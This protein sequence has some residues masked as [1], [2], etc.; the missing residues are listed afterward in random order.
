MKRPFLGTIRRKLLSV[1]LLT[2]LVAVIVALGAMIGYDLRNHYDDL[3]SDMTTQSE[4]LGHMTAPA[5]TF[6]DHQLADQ[7]LGMLVARPQVRAAAIYTPRNEIFSTYAAKGHKQPIPPYPEP[8]SVRIEGRDLILFKRITSNGE[9]IGTV[10]LSVD[11]GFFERVLAYL[12]IAALV[13]LLAMSIAFL[14]SLRLQ[15]VV[16]H[17]IMAISRVAREVVEQRDY[18]RRADNTSDD[19]VGVLVDSFND[20]LN[21]IERRTRDLESSN[22]AIARE[23]DERSRAQQEIMR[24]NAELE[25]RVSVRTAQLQLSNE[26]LVAAKAGADKASQAKSEFLSSMSHEIRTPMN[27]VI[28]MVDVLHQTSL[29]DYQVEM[30]DLIRE[31]ALS[32]MTIIDDILDFSKIEAGK[33]ELDVGPLAV[34]DIVEKV[35]NMLDRLAE[36]KS[37]E[38]TMFI[39]P[40]IPAEVLGDA[41]RVRQVLTNLIN[42]AIKFSS[43]QDRPGIVSVRTVL[44]GEQPDQLFVEFQVSDNGIG[45]DEEIQA[46][47]F[48][49]FTQADSTTTRRFGGTGL[50]LSISRHLVALMNGHI[51]VQSMLGKGSVFTVRLPFTRLPGR[52]DGANAAAPLAGLQ[53]LA[54]GDLQGLADGI[55]TYLESAGARVHCVPS[56]TA[57]RMKAASAPGV[58]VW[59]V[60]TVVE[61]LPFEELRA[62]GRIRADQETRFVAIARGMRRRPRVQATDLVVVNGNVLAR[63][64]LLQAVAMV[65]GRAEEEAPAHRGIVERVIRQPSKED[66]R[67]EGRLILVAEDNETNQKVILRQLSLLGYAA[68]V[69]NDGRQALERWKSEDFGLLL[70]DLHMPEM[71]GYQLCATIRATED[72][73]T[74]RPIIALS[75][76]AL[77]DE[78]TRCRAMGMDDYLAKPV[79]LTD[80][81]AALKK[82]LPAIAHSRHETG[83]FDASQASAGPVDV[84]V[85]A[86]LVGDDPEI[87]R[88]FL[89]NF[90]VSAYQIAAE[91]KC[92]CENGS[93]AEAGAMA[94]KLKSSA[95]SVGALALG[96]LCAELEKAGKAGRLDAVATLLPK[97]E[98]EMATVNEYLKSL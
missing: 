42:N 67:R 22:Q 80:L 18:S 5:L 76:N 61:P 8:D 23:A 81:E 85:L 95:R 57:A 91:L 87:I 35:C 40:E 83:S 98:T 69:V 2:T 78:A 10:Y 32:L 38:L 1:V 44:V 17:P 79:R 11:H 3:T 94:H 52:T 6:D 60:D 30:V 65:A 77:K 66:S 82:W 43:G 21:E 48:S 45:M 54:V 34:G 63:G 86:A 70:T 62:A 7:N 27:G 26:E 56:V 49:S 59:I 51:A 50:G 84:S 25:E 71:D 33:L 53:C 93:V 39:D 15:K 90:Q 24:L 19:E 64:M 47:I 37:V 96:E 58:V 41:L 75:A 36:K 13:T 73:S 16:T 46:R 97:F 14:L 12:G 20:M 31:S 9:F 28:G 4:L 88:D 68:E 89:Q 29:K 72:S 92:A 74:R 55:V